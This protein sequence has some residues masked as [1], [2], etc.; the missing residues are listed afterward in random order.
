MSHTHKEHKNMNEG[1]SQDYTITEQELI[2]SNNR[3]KNSQVKCTR[4]EC[5]TIL[6]RERDNS[7]QI[8]EWWRSNKDHIAILI[9]IIY[10]L[11][12]LIM[13]AVVGW[14]MRISNDE[15]GSD[16]LAITLTRNSRNRI[17][18][19]AEDNTSLHE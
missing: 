3:L 13:F 10:V 14:N 16:H 1:V 4:D 18:A 15:P 19:M 8:K 12:F 6:E 9:V 5:I 17:L 2:S 11:V 7:F